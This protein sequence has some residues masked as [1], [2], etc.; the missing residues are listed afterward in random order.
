MFC[1]YVHLMVMVMDVLMVMVTVTVMVTGTLTA[2]F[3]CFQEMPKGCR[4]P[5]ICETFGHCCKRQLQAEERRNVGQ[6]TQS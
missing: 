3:S 5:S 4:R 2:L 6:E 1:Q